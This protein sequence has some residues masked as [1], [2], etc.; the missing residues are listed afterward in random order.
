MQRME[1]SSAKNM[2]SVAIQ[3]SAA[4]PWVVKRIHSRAQTM[5]MD[6]AEST[7]QMAMMVGY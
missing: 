1:Y 6:R 4:R 2:D 3:S 5:A 7:V